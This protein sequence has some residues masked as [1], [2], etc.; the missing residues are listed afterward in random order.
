MFLP[1]PLTSS[2]AK[3]LSDF[4]HHSR[5]RRH[6]SRVGSVVKARLYLGIFFVVITVYYA[7]VYASTE[8]YAKQRFLVHEIPLFA[9]T[10]SLLLGAICRQEWARY[11]LIAFLIIRVGS[12]LIFLPTYLESPLLFFEEAISPV[13]DSLLIWALISVPSI[14]RLVARNY[15]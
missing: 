6:R 13:L 11:L 12:T 10:A 5:R 3:D 9:I 15:E 14:R 2:P 8:D 7:W 1:D 4:G